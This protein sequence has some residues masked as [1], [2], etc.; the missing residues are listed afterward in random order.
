M[1]THSQKTDCLNKILQDKNKSRIE[2]LPLYINYTQPGLIDS[3]YSKVEQKNGREHKYII[4]LIGGI[5][6]PSVIGLLIS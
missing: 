3:S 1:Q 2:S 4:Y 6:D 5:Y